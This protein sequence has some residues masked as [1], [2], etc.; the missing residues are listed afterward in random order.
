MVSVVLLYTLHGAE[1]LLCHDECSDAAID[2][3]HGDSY[4]F[5]RFVRPGTTALLY[6]YALDISKQVAENIDLVYHIRQELGIACISWRTVRSGSFAHWTTGLVLLP[7]GNL[8]E[9]L[10]WLPSGPDCCQS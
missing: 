1:I 5:F 7:P 6:V 2:E 9:V 3:G 4:C 8:R 10:V